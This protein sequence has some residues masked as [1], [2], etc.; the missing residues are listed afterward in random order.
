MMSIKL[1]LCSI[2]RNFTVSGK[3]T[4]LEIEVDFVIKSKDGFKLQLH[5]RNK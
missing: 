2:L 4:E 3:E 5:R 1:V